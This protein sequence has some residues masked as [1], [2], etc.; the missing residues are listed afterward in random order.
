[1]FLFVECSL[2]KQRI[3][4]TVSLVSKKRSWK[5]TICDSSG[6][7]RR[8][9][10]HLLEKSYLSSRWSYIS[11]FLRYNRRWFCKNVLIL[12]ETGSHTQRRN[13]KNSRP[14]TA[15]SAG[16]RD[17]LCVGRSTLKYTFSIQLT[18]TCFTNVTL[19]TCTCITASPT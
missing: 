17:G 8:M 1:M 19:P 10:L 5:H 18:S 14:A 15:T 6:D 2:W 13:N 9:T 12:A 16:H 11:T 7:I 4:L 3:K